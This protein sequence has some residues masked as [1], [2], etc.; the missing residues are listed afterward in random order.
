MKHVTGHLAAYLGGELD[1]PTRALVDAHLAECAACRAELASFDQVWAMLDVAASAPVSTGPGLWN[2]VRSR[3]VAVDPARVPWFF[4]RGPWTRRGW[5]AV[6]VA[7]GVFVALVLPGGT[8]QDGTGS[9]ALASADSAGWLASTW[10]DDT[11]NPG[12]AEQWML[13]GL[14]SDG[15]T[16]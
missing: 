10:L 11:S 16:P 13:A 15:S 3:T 12:L 7:A 2:G 14:D 1:Q 8:G 9:T 4:G 6:A 5:A